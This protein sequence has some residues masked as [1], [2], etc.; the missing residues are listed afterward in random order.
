MHISS[1][2]DVVYTLESELIFSDGFSKV[3]NLSVGLK[4]NRLCSVLLVCLLEHTD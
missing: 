2:C 4:I 3:D 1:A